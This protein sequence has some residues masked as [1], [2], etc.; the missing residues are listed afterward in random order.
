MARGCQ[1]CW[2]ISWILHRS[3]YFKPRWFLFKITIMPVGEVDK[4]GKVGQGGKVGKVGKW[5]QLVNL[6]NL[7]NQV[8]MANMVILVN[9]VKILKT[10]LIILNCTTQAQ[11]TLPCSA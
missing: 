8:N 10:G 3:I 4:V 2:L 11:C 7:L 6:E 9:L 1:Y 5:V